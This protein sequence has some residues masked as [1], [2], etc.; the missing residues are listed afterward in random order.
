MS[1]LNAL[2]VSTKSVIAEILE[3]LAAL[4]PEQFIEPDLRPDANYHAVGE[5]NDDVKRL[6]TLRSIAC[7][8]HNLLGKSIVATVEKIHQEMK[9]AK[10]NKDKVK[11]LQE[12][13]ELEDDPETLRLM[14]E[15]ARKRSFHDIVDKI[16]WLEIRRQ[17]PELSEKPSVSVRKNWTVGWCEKDDSEDPHGFDVLFGGGGQPEIPAELLE[18]LGSRLR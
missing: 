10:T 13:V 6:F 14:A 3:R 7:D 2:V 4:K 16:F 17:Y 12:I 1:Q 11:A 18:L 8:E 5:A 9:R 15:M